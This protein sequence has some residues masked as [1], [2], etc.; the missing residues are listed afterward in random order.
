M[1]IAERELVR[2]RWRRA[3]EPLGLQRTGVEGFAA[4]GLA[5]RLETPSV[6]LMLLPSDPEEEVLEFD[7]AFTTW[8]ESKRTIDLGDFVVSLP[9]TLRRTGHALALVNLFGDEVWGKY[10]AVYRS[11][12]LEYGLG[13]DG[14]WRTQGQTAGS[15]RVVA[16]SAVVARTWAFLYVAGA[17]AERLAMSGPF[18][19]TVAVPN[20]AGALLGALGEGWAQPGTF[21]NSTGGCPD[22]ELLWHM[23]LTALPGPDESQALAYAIGDRLESAWGSA[24]RRYLARAGQFSGRIDPRHT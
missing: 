6:R 7:D 20:T 22:A 3:L 5:D 11:G 2:A 21:R 13:E 8:F 10:L 4:T 15:R 1:N 17:L 19:L 12:A 24:Q 14:G 18:L 16:L 23:E 9:G